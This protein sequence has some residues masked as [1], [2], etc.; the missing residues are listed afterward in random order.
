MTKPKKAVA[1]RPLPEGA[2]AEAAAVDL[3]K[4]I[5]ELSYRGEVH[6]LAWQAVP[7]DE[8]MACR[9]QTSYP[10]EDVTG[11]SG[12]TPDITIVCILVWLARRASG[13]PG[14]SY[15]RHLTTWPVD[16]TM[17]EVRT[18]TFQADSAEA[19]LTDPQS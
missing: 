10:W 14:L 18:R 15:R 5:L 3:S 1:P 7:M 4:Q 19:D 13:E 16:M 17:A 8:R 11:I 12:I 2:E 9:L 6:T